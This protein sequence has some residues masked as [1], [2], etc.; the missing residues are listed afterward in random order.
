MSRWLKIACLLLVIFMCFSLISCTNSEDQQEIIDTFNSFASDDNYIF[1]TIYEFHL[2]KT[3]I[4]NSELIYNENRCKFLTSTDDCAYGYCESEDGAIA[5]IVS[6][7]YESL[8]ISLY[9]TVI[10]PSDLIHASFYDNSFYFRT[11]DPSTEE[12]QQIYTIYDM[13]NKEISTCNTDDFID[14]VERRDLHRDYEFEYP[15][16]DILG[17]LKVKIINIKTGETKKFSSNNLKECEE[18]K[19]IYK[20]PHR[21]TN[22]GTI[23]SDIF[24][25]GNDIYFL[26]LQSI[27]FLG[28]PSYYFIVKYNFNTENVEYCSTIYFEDYPENTYFFYIPNTENST[29]N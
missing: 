5:Y 17:N 19:L 12:F 14:V 2:G 3:I 20:L 28:Y 8:E 25:D 9:D 26:C 27:G 29:L 18:G 21:Q 1:Q 6:L 23:P 24:V 13:A 16:L 7:D 10:L 11:D 22:L 4:P 15:D